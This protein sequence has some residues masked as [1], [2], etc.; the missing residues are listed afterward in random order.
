MTRTA[1]LRIGIDVSNAVDPRPTGV[2]RYVRRLVESLLALAAPPG[3]RIFCRPSRLRRGDPRQLVPELPLSWL[4]PIAA[5]RGIELFHGPDVRL[6]RCA[7][8]PLVATI[9]DL[10]ALE[11]EDHA[12]PS[13]LRR[14]RAAYAD[15]ARRAAAIITHAEHVRAAVI[16]CLRVPDDRV[17]RIPLADGLAGV[18]ADRDSEPARRANTLLV[19]GGPSRRKG[20]HRL[21]A[22]IA[23]WEARLGWS[24]SIEWVGSGSPEAADALLATLGAEARRRVRFLGHVPD[25]ELDRLYREATGLL[26]LS[27]SEGFAMPLIEAAARGCPVLALRSAPLEEALGSDAFWFGDPFEASIERFRGFLIGTERRA[28][29]E[30]AARRAAAF[31]WRATAER[32]L[33]VYERVVA[34]TH[35][36][37]G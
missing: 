8:A 7:R 18:T 27:E 32:T 24:P 5:P 20:S 9:H 35:Q 21:A 29:A 16:E 37:S 14:K 13:Y 6:P 15:A 17:V 31:Q 26:M 30:R 25:V 2:A 10:T 22:L 3:I 33:E 34:S 36:R 28:V 19:V 12:L 11:R 4:L 23:F 1:R